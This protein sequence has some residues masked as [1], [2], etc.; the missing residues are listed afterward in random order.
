MKSTTKNP[1]KLDLVAHVCNPGTQK[2]E[3]GDPGI[4]NQL[5]IQSKPEA[6][7]SYILFSLKKKIS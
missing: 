5:E 6:S 2:G 1:G 3:E 4:Q 7:L